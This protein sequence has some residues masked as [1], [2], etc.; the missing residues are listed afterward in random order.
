MVEAYAFFAAF[1]AQILIMSVL[2]PA[3]FV[4]NLRAKLAR[5]P[6]GR[7]AQVY[8]DVD[9]NQVLEQFITRY[10]V[11]TT[12]I[13]VLGLLLLGWLLIG[14]WRAGWNKDVAGFLSTGYFMVAMLLPLLVFGRS[15]FN[16]Q[17]RLAE[18]KRTAILQR[19]GLFDFVSPFVV[20]LAVLTYFL[21]VAFLFYIEQHPFP[22]YAGPLINII[23]VTLIYAMNA[24]CLYMVM[25]GKKGPLDTHEGRLHTIGLVAR[26][27]V[28]SCIVIVVALSLT[29]VFRM[30]ELKSWEPFAGSIFYIIIAALASLGFAA[31]PGKQQAE[32][33]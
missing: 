26:G 27:S 32:P 3:W 7:L 15:R 10:R 33:A 5:L 28:C 6:A 24:F 22:G 9:A 29:H 1:T 8:P 17:H 18:G 21:Y 11:L 31:P 14:A 30:Q 4:S 25:H 12:G 16:K 20:F 2:L 23:G 19:R 13:A